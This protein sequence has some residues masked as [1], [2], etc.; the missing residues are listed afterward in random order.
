MSL[1]QEG[2]VCLSS[3]LLGFELKT[4]LLLNIWNIDVVE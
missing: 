2:F 3:R 1:T 4:I